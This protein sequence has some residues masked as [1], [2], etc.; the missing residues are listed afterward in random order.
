MYTYP[1]DTNSKSYL[2]PP[3]LKSLT[4]SSYTLQQPV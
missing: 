3:Q 4:H 2:K 1:C